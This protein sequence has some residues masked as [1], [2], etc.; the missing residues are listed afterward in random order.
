MT[1]PAIVWFREDLRLADNPALTAACARGGPVLCVYILD[2]ES[3]GMRAPGGAARRYLHHALAALSASLARSGG[4]LDLYRGPAETVLRDLVARSGAG[5]LYWN[6][7]Y[8]GAETALDARIKTACDGVCEVRSFSGKLL[9]EPWTALNRSGAPFRVFTPFWRAAQDRIDHAPPLPAPARLVAAAPAGAPCAL[10][11]LGLEPTGP[12]WAGG[13]RA[14]WRAGEAAARARLVAFLDERLARYAAERDL[15]HV[16][17]TSR[18]SPSLAFGE[19][20]PRQIR[21]AVAHAVDAQP[22]LARAADKFM[23]E[24]GWRE[25]SWSLLFHFPDLPAVNFDRRFDAFPWRA[26]DEAARDIAAWTAGRTGYPLVDAGMRELWAT[27]YMHNRV[28][29]VAASFLTKHLL[30][31]WRV[32]ERWFW[33]TLCDADAANNTASWQWVAGC[34]ADA[35]PYFRIFNPVLQ[36]EKFDP[37]GAYVRRWLPELAATPAK[38]VHKPWTAPQRPADYPA[39]IV[40]H[41]FARRRA[42]AAF[43]RLRAV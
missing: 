3:E 39:P 34:G 35:A 9:A 27:G 4:R 23:S 12:D 32:G 22:A 2:E 36:G 42:L 37:D 14:T 11:A 33:D 40:D 20:S 6:R 5:A 21:A 31:D 1:E 8:G 41:D 38:F 18:L 15:P 25:F 16:E 26:E 7:R 43:E 19:I 30:V 17:A 24:V 10:G 28:R 29:M 13:L